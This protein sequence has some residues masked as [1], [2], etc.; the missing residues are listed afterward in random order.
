MNKL[1]DQLFNLL[2]K[3]SD[4]GEFNQLIGDIGEP[5]RVYEADDNTIY[6]FYDQGFGITS[7]QNN[8]KFWMLGFEFATLPVKNGA[9]KAF[10]G[11]L[12]SGITSKDC[13]SDVEAKLGVKP[14]S[15][16]IS[17]NNKRCTGRYELLPLQFTCVFESPEGALEG[18]SIYSL[19][20]AR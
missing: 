10:A 16:R 2:G 14:K 4:S 11:E 20:H 13:A 9:M 8:K 15:L 5:S 1:Y 6:E 12:H 18:M 7:K 19:E 17:E 3:R